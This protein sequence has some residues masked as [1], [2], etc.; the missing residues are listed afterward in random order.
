MIDV[1]RIDVR[2][3]GEKEIDDGARAGEVKRR[4]SIAAA[5]VHARR[6]G[7]DHPGQELRAIEMGRRA[8]VGDGPRSDQPFG[9]VTGGRVQR[10]KAACPPCAALI[11][12]GAVVEQ[13]VDDRAIVGVGDDRRR[14]E[15]EHGVVDPC[16]ELRML[17]EEP[18]QRIRVVV[19]ERVVHA[20]ERRA[21]RVRSLVDVL[22]ER[23][24]VGE[25][26][27]AR[28]HELRVGEGDVLFV[29]QRGSDALAC[30]DVAGSKSTKQLLRLLLLLSEIRMCGERTAE[31]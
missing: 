12:I 6:I 1:S 25:S 26:V 16:A 8:G 10:M 3:A 7:G 31:R 13:Y 17:F 21:R 15:A 27:F 30:I 9:R 4:L 18:P 29:G 2:A 5:F 24:P 28:E 19:S 14:V 11:G 23:R 20:L 22:F